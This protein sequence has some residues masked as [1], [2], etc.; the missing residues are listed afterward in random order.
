[1]INSDNI[2]VN[3][4]V[5]KKIKED[6]MNFYEESLKEAQSFL[7]DFELDESNF[8]AD[9]SFEVKKNTNNVISIL[10][11]YYKYSGGAHGYYEYVPY[12][13]NLKNGNMISLKDIFKNDVDYKLL[14]CIVTYLVLISPYSSNEFFTIFAK[15]VSQRF[16]NKKG[17]NR[18]PYLSFPYPISPNNPYTL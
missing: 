5:N 9:A 11:K 18:L 8:V 1:M 12:N 16:T 4:K 14:F 7:D 3:N 10:I 13:I 2:E 17:N 15:V 6:I